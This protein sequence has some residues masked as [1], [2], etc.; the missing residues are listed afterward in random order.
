MKKK[1]NYNE[2]KLVP[3]HEKISEKQKQELLEKYN[4]TLEDLPKIKFS[5]PALIGM[6][7]KVGDI[8]KIERFSRTEGISVFYRRV[9]NE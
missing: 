4:S 3:K 7:A 5:D 8:I 2:H 9:V 6:D 1:I